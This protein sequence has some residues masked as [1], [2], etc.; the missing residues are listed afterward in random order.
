MLKQFK[1]VLFMCGIAIFSVMPHGMRAMGANERSERLLFLIENSTNE[2]EILEHLQWCT[3][4]D[5]NYVSSVWVDSGV[6]GG[7]V[8]VEFPLGAAAGYAR[9]NLVL[10]LIGKGAKVNKKD[11]YLELTALHKAIEAP[12]SAP[13][14]D[15]CETVKILLENGANPN[16]ENRDGFTA[17]SLACVNG[18]ADLIKLFFNPLVTKIKPDLKK[19]SSCGHS[20]LFDILAFDKP[21][22][23]IV[24]LFVEN[25]ADVDEQIKINGK[26]YSLAAYVREFRDA[27]KIYYRSVSGL[28][29]SFPNYP[30]Q[31]IADYLDVALLKKKLAAGIKKNISGKELQV[32]ANGVKKFDK[33]FCESFLS[34]DDFQGNFSKIPQEICCRFDPIN[35]SNLT[36]VESQNEQQKRSNMVKS[37][38]NIHFVG[39][40]ECPKCESRRCEEEQKS[41]VPT[42]YNALVPY[43]PAAVAGL[44]ELKK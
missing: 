33:T 4:K 19:K 39:I 17:F 29:F 25:G 14:K 18:D 36:L 21:S 20:L 16:A 37:D 6:L 5:V 44:L 11:P 8:Q 10:S 42:R 23:E 30:T 7:Y 35:T 26:E 15:V 3:K 24:K 12:M 28:C 27:S 41:L 43:N 31:E 34:L 22:F 9:S 40:C 2:D 1:K 38:I 32:I 13:K